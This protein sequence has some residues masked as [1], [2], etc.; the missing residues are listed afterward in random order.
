MEIL[1]VAAV[2][3]IIPYFWYV[4]IIGRK[5]KVLEAL[6]GIDAQLTKRHDLL[7]NVFTLAQ[8]FMTHERTLLEE[9]TALRQ[10]AQAGVGAKNASSVKEHLQ[11]EANLSG[12]LGQFFALAENYPDLKSD[13]TILEA[14]RACTEV[15]ENLSAARRFYNNAVTVLNNSVQIFPG[16]LI[17]KMAGV[18]AYPFY[19]AEEAHRKPIN[20]ADFLK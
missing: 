8:K 7:P 19:T 12:K 9:I 15:E 1:I 17:A 10:Q 2:L 18:E 4:S 14:Q 6:G 5:N 11:L 20:A 3:L 13:T 16:S